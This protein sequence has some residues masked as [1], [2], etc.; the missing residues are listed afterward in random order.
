MDDL[1][2]MIRV[3]ARKILQSRRKGRAVA[4]MLNRRIISFIANYFTNGTGV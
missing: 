4:A 1:L 2:P 3:A